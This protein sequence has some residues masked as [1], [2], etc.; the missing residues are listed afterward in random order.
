MEVWFAD[1]LCGP[2]RDLSNVQCQLSQWQVC[3]VPNMPQKN[4]IRRLS[5]VVAWLLTPNINSKAPPNFELELHISNNSFQ[6]SVTQNVGQWLLMPVGREAMN[7]SRHRTTTTT[8][9][10][11]TDNSEPLSQDTQTDDTTG[12]SPDVPL[13]PPGQHQKSV[14]S[15]PWTR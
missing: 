10:A 12:P 5:S 9:H 8:T 7:L 3:Q 1:M 2:G 15:I 14:Q 13:L 11:T 6:P 4:M